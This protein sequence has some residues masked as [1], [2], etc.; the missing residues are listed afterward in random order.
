MRFGLNMDKYSRM[1][2][3][4]PASDKYTSM[5]SGSSG[6]EKYA[7]MAGFS[8][9]SMSPGSLLAA[10][11]T[12]QEYLSKLVSL[13]QFPQGRGASALTGVKARDGPEADAYVAECVRSQY[14]RQANPAG[15]YDPSCT[16]GSA[17]GH[18][19]ASRK[20]ALSAAFRAHH[21]SSAQKVGDYFETRRRALTVA[22]GCS[23]EEYLV[24]RFPTAASAVVLG[25]AE[26][27]RTCVRYGVPS[28]PAEAYMVRSVDAA[29][30][31]RAVSTGVYEPSCSD[32]GSSG[33]ADYK[34]VQAL[35]A[36]YRSA[37]VSAGAAAQSKYDSAAYARQHFGHACSYEDNLFGAYPAMAAA[38]RPSTAR[39]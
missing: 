30:K 34:R 38:M 36:K 17:K 26:A 15:V 13:R 14:K 29:M 3:G 39:Y 12:W 21:R 27:G 19:E 5:S 23:Y 33:E 35:A 10:E 32:G 16:E 8:P 6:L 24:G 9:S 37:A 22:G 20:A 1:A 2:G 18:A 7:R 28:S 25:A 4:K 11:G 31:R